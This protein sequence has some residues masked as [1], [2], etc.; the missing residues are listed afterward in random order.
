MGV[1]TKICERCKEEFP[2]S[3][4]FYL[5]RICSKCFEGEREQVTS[6]RGEA[7]VKTKIK[8]IRERFLA[9]IPEASKIS[10]EEMMKIVDSTLYGAKIKLAIEWED[11]KEGLKQELGDTLIG[12]FFRWMWGLK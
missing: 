3:A 9:R 6:N 11:L 7:I 2:D 5:N 4:Y 1:K 12:R 10:D 8:R